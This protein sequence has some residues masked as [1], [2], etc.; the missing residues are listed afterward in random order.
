MKIRISIAPLHILGISLTAFF[1]GHPEIYRDIMFYDEGVYVVLTKALASGAGYVHESLPGS[2]L[3]GKYPPFFPLFLSAIWALFPNFPDNL[4]VMR[5]VVAAIGY[6]FLV[7][8]F[9]YLTEIIRISAL[10]AAG[11]I[12]MIAF[13]PV[14]IEYSFLI[15]SEIPY[16]LLSMTTLY[17]YSRF[18]AANK[19]ATLGLVFFLASLAA[20]TRTVGFVLFAAL[21]AHLLVTRRIKVCLVVALYAA[22][23]FFF[24]QVWV[25]HTHQ[26][27]VDYPREIAM[28]YV[29]YTDYLTHA[30][31]LGNLQN[32]LLINLIALVKNWAGLV[33]PWGE[34]MIV[35][36]IVLTLGLYFYCRQK[37]NN[38][39]LADI[40]CFLSLVIIAFWPWP[41]SARF[42]LVSS[43]LLI[44]F[45]LIGI[46]KLTV[47]IAESH[48]SGKTRQLLVTSISCAIVA[49]AVIHNVVS[50]ENNRQIRLLSLPVYTELR[51]SLDWLRDNTSEQ[52]VVVGNRDSAFYLFT[53]RKAVRASYP[54]PYKIWYA[55]EPSAEFPETRTLKDWFKNIG[56]CYFIQETSKV[57]GMS[58]IYNSKL[59]EAMKNRPDSSYLEI[60]TSPNRWVSVYK[61]TNCVKAM[62]Q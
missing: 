30:D 48:I 31:W 16:A 28:N 15:V 19:T 35:A 32:M 41:L 47:K 6:L 9:K 23:L 55:S 26:G 39:S 51:D 53:G 27:Y 24:W 3:E 49:A 46:R 38:P 21:A 12:A 43:P 36:Y 2:P 11:I 17:C 34:R 44:A 57:S 60:Y 13:H 50:I 45:C 61:D 33:F 1:F 58:G 4:V 20:L 14:F 52:A 5:L 40:Y 62:P 7:V 10:E 37:L 54:D 42:L 29:G 22:T 56:A 8:S 25:W 18:L 59:L